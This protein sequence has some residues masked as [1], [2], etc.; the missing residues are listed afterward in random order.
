M[1]LAL[2]PDA[3][4]DVVLKTDEGKPASERPTFVYRHVSGRDWKP[5]LEQLVKAEQGDPGANIDGIFNAL[6]C[7]LAGW[8]HMVDPKTKQEIPFDPVELDRLLT[9]GE[10]RQLFDRIAEQGIPSSGEAEG[11]ESPVSSAGANSVEDA[12]PVNA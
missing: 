8:R 12:A 4:F 3:T 9:F 1:P 2:D 10:A 11:S 7:G 5:R 6:R